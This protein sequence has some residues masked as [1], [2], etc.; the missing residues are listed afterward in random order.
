MDYFH[1]SNYQKEG[2][3][4][5]RRRRPERNNFA[6]ITNELLALYQ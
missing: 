1:F 6:C 4:E 2:R 3:R 5:W